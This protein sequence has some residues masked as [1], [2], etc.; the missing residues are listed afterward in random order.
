MLRFARND[1]GA[2]EMTWVKYFMESFA[3]KP[4]YFG[5]RM[6]GYRDNGDLVFFRPVIPKDPIGRRRGLLGIRLK[7]LFFF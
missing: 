2:V 4:K 7:N 1:G 3:C 6:R 5:L